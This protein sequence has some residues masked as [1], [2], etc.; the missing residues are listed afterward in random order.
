[1][2]LV[3]KFDSD[4]SNRNYNVNMNSINTTRI[5]YFLK[6]EAI[7]KHKKNFYLKNMT[8]MPKN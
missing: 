2:N 7:K 3:G 5:Q 1:M 4:N 6:P 8:S